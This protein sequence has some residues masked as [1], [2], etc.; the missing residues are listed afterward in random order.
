MPVISAVVRNNLILTALDNGL[1]NWENRKERQPVLRRDTLAMTRSSCLLHHFVLLP[2]ILLTLLGDV[3][4]FLWLCLRP[5][6]ALAAENL[7]LR[8]QLALYR[9]RCLKPQRAP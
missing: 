1:P 3:A 9:E 2:W 4:H 5:P 7:F 6:A 8:K